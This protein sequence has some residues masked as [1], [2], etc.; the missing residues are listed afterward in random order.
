M[1]DDEWGAVMHW[2]FVIAGELYTRGVPIPEDWQ[3]KP[4]LHPVDFDS[5][6]SFIVAG[7]TTEVLM[8]FME[9]V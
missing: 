3:Y 4:G 8:R 6:E 2:W 7:A 9:D 5:R 1:E